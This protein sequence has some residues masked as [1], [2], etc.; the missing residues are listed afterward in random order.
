M[1]CDGDDR[2]DPEAAKAATAT[3][4][5]VGTTLAKVVAEL[6]ELLTADPTLTVAQGLGGLQTVSV[7]DA[8]YAIDEMLA[9]KGLGL[10]DKMFLFMEGV[11]SRLPAVDGI[12]FDPNTRPTYDREDSDAADRRMIMYGYAYW[13]VM[14]AMGPLMDL[15]VD[16][17]PTPEDLPGLYNEDGI[18]EIPQ[19]ET[20]EWQD[21]HDW[22]RHN[23]KLYVGADAVL[24]K[25]G[26]G[27]GR[28]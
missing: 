24:F 21:F 18:F 20:E 17:A 9:W 14:R 28:W 27:P 11:A 2:P 22:T 12:V 15:L 26:F 23:V 6:S 7:A 5:L 16:T 13:A 3:G 1:A 4:E 25:L 8:G 19:P 10:P